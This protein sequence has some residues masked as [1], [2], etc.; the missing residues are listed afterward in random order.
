MAKI[1]KIQKNGVDIYPVTHEDAV[2]D[3]EGISIGEKIDNMN[4]IKADKEEVTQE[5]S[6]KADKSEI[7]TKISDL[8]DDLGLSGV[9][10]TSL[11]TKEDESLNTNDKTIVGAINEVKTNKVDKVEGKDLIDIDEINRLSNVDNYD[12]SEVREL[13]DDK[14]DINKVEQ[15]NSKVD[16]VASK[17]EEYAMIEESDIDLII[18][19]INNE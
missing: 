7:P 11:Q 13:I 4:N 17:V 2:I 19:D 8:E 12:D 10:L 15:V 9:D 16:L 18:A 1:K 14:A 3:N 5:L 6:T